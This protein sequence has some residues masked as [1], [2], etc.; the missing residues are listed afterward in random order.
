MIGSKKIFKSLFLIYLFFVLSFARTFVGVTFFGFRIGEITMGLCMLVLLTSFI[1]TIY[2]KEYLINKT[3]NIS[4]ALLVLSFVLIKISYGETLINPYSI[5]ASSYIW[6]VGAIF[7]G[8]YFYKNIKIDF[9]FVYL[10]YSILLWVYYFSI[11]GVS[12]ELQNFILQFTDK[13]EYH[14]GT[15]VLIVFI[16]ATY[17]S[18]RVD[19]QTNLNFELFFLFS[20]LFFPLIVFKTRA[21]SFAFLIYVVLEMINNRKY[22]YKLNLRKVLLFVIALMLMLQSVFFV[23]KSGVVEVEKIEEN[24]TFLSEYRDPGPNENSTIEETR[25]LYFNNSRLYSGDG[26]LN[27]RLQI[28]QDVYE[29]LKIQNKLYTGFGFED[30]I[31]AM[32]DPFRAG[33]DGTN[34][35]VHNFVVNV[36]ARGGYLHL[37]LYLICLISIFI[38]F[39]SKYT[40]LYF[41][42]FYITIFF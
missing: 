29:D 8:I 23:T 5:K 36:F 2:T 16:F 18:N 11:Y 13:F 31:P 33:N 32:D 17:L 25:F 21:G 7:I 39:K 3:F 20:F 42:I 14:K 37:L 27:W 34:E 10:Y 30:K 41:N 24:V 9:K 26:N 38:Y 1:N 6:S 12:N 22:F 4:L 40:I 19:K 15:D 28:W 35:N